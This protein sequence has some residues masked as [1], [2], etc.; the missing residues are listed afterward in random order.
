MDNKTYVEI[1]IQTE[2]NKSTQD[3]STQVN[4]DEEEKLIRGKTIK[5]EI[6]SNR[7]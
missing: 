6:T 3:K 4:M 7:S 1:G 5:K 2:E